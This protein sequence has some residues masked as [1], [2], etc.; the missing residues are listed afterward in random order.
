MSGR[1]SALKAVQATRGLLRDLKDN[2][3]R[4]FQNVL[5]K[6]EPHF[7]CIKVV[8]QEQDQ[9]RESSYV[10][11]ARN[12]RRQPVSLRNNIYAGR[13]SVT[14]ISEATGRLCFSSGLTSYTDDCKMKFW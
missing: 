14:A 10:I 2:P 1:F 13:T 7:K 12:Q 4:H 3:R 5:L 9:P 8:I 11:D 6:Y